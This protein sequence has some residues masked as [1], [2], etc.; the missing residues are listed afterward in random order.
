MTELAPMKK[1]CTA[2]PLVRCSSGSIS[3]MN[4]R[5]GC[6][7]TLMEPSISHSVPAATQSAGELGMMSS[8]SD[9]RIA[10]ARK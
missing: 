10:P 8:A 4:A 2:N 3:P 6:I 7:V 5:N 1:V 9:D